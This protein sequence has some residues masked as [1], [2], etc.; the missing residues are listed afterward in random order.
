MKT[1]PHAFLLIASMVLTVSLACLAGCGGSGETSSTK[2]QSPAEKAQSKAQ[3]PAEKPSPPKRSPAERARYIKEKARFI[4]QGNAICRR[5]DA[6]QH[7]R[8]TRYLKREG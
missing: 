5:A 1:K 4:K 7:K 2:P 8:V 6:E 3:S